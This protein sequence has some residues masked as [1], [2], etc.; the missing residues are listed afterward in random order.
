MTARRRREI[1]RLIK[2]M[3]ERHS[4]AKS[5]VLIAKSS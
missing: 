5:N 1:G 4:G 3:V 2:P